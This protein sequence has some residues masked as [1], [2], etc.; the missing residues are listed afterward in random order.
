MRIFKAQA[1]TVIYLESYKQ[2][3]KLPRS[4]MADMVSFSV[5]SQRSKSTG[6]ESDIGLQ[7]G[8][9]KK[10]SCYTVIDIAKFIL[11]KVKGQRVQT[12]RA[13]YRV[14]Q[15]KKVSCYTVIDIAKARQ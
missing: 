7:G 13:I 8:S 11:F 2:H 4:R 1:I 9:N 5:Q 10:V 15:I 14:D 12:A 6:S 3:L